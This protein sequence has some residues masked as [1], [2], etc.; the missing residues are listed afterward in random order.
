MLHVSAVTE[1]VKPVFTVSCDSTYNND[2]TINLNAAWQI[3]DEAW[4]Q[5]AIDVFHV[6]P[7]LMDFNRPTAPLVDSY[8]FATLDTDVCDS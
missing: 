3:P 6:I 5:E 1:P 7:S 2:G 4:L 8:T